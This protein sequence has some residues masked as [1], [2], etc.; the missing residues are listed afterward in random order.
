MPDKLDLYLRRIGL[1]GRPSPDADGL[2]AVQ[3][4]QRRAIAFENLD[5]Q[6]GRPIRIDNESVFDKLVTRRRGGYCFEQNR[7][8]SDMLGA[9]GLPNRPLLARVRLGPSGTVPPRTHVLLLLEIS[10][11]PWLADAGFGGSLVLPMPLRDGAQCATPDGAQHHLRRVGERG[12]LGGEWLLERAGPATAT[13]GRAAPHGDWQPQYTFDLAEVA[14][15]DLEQANH[16]TSTRPDTRFTAL[17][18]VSIVLPAGFASLTD[19]NLT[20][21]E[22]GA[23]QSREIA[24]VDDCRSIL[25]GR[26]GLDLAAEEI[27]ALPL[28]AASGD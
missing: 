25:S 12:S 9:V 15:E 27:A 5:I 13:D 1:S 26:F 4:A 8:F 3:L 17:H 2:A 7:L 19:R 18:V 11:Q 23:T 14:P 20:V 6:L 10:G 16:W 22:N 21:F 24:D 28:F